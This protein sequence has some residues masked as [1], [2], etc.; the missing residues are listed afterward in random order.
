[1]TDS[2]RTGV[3]ARIHQLLALAASD[4][5]HEARNAAIIAARMIRSEGVLLALP[6]YSR[7]TG[8][9]AP[10]E[11]LAPIVIQSKFS[12]LCRSC[13]S[14][15]AVGDRVQWARGKGAAHVTCPWG[16]S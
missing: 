9:S 8:A 14:S 13:G 7:P 2:T 15:Y 4:N 1:M 5:E 11:G 12:G 6:E 10:T 16:L 3:L